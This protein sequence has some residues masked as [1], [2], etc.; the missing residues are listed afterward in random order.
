MPAAATHNSLKVLGARVALGDG[1]VALSQESANRSTDNVGATEHDNGSAREVGASAV[2]ELDDTGGGA[3][4]EDG[5]GN[6]GGKVTNVLGVESG[7]ELD[8][9]CRLAHRR[10]SQR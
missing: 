7:G 8:T 5:L 6:A 3:G 10:P 1:G 9:S 2:N 4:C